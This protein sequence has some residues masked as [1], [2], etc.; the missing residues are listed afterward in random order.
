MWKI[1][2]RDK[3]LHKNKLCWVPVAHTYNPSSS[4]GSLFNATRGK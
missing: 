3:H 2:P 4:G 1:D